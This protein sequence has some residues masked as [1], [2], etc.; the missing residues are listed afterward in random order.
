MR[1]LT[2]SS[3]T[4]FFKYKKGRLFNSAY[5]FVQPLDTDKS[6]AQRSLQFKIPAACFIV[7]HWGSLITWFSTGTSVPSERTKIFFPSF[8]VNVNFSFINIPPFDYE[9]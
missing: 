8:S 5:A 3:I 7:T 1:E 4:D 2:Y 9:K 6:R